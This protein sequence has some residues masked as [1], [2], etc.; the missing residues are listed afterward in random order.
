MD[1]HLLADNPMRSEHGG[2]AI[3]RTVAPIGIFE[4]IEGHLFFDV[5]K[6]PKS[7]RHYKHYSYFEEKY[8]MKLHYYGGFNE[9]APTADQALILANKHMDDAWHWYMNYMQWENE[10]LNDLDDEVD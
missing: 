2:L 1:K 8:T 7:Y 9:P 4:I 3:I 5:E 10:N 6:T